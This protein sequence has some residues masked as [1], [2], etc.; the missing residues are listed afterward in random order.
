MYHFSTTARLVVFPP[1]T[2]QISHY[3]KWLC[4]QEFKTNAKV[5]CD[6]TIPGSSG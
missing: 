1:V 3:Q 6:N 5:Y 4:A 2:S